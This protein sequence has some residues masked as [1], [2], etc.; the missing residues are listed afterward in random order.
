MNHLGKDYL[1]NVIIISNVICFII[2]TLEQQ[3]I[4]FMIKTKKDK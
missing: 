2:I 3:Q 4:A 1:A